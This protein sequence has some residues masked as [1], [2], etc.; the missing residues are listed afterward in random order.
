MTQQWDKYEADLEIEARKSNTGTGHEV[1]ENIAKGQKGPRDALTQ[2]KDEKKLNANA[3][4][5]L[6]EQSKQAE[7]LGKLNLPHNLTQLL[8][9]NGKVMISFKLHTLKRVQS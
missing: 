9:E 7:Q 4:D 5:M 8:T 1:A 2:N 6:D 3:I